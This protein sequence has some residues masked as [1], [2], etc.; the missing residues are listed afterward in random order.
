MANLL[1][2]LYKQAAQKAYSDGIDSGNE[3]QLAK[4]IWSNC[5]FPLECYYYLVLGIGCELA[6]IQA[7]KQGFLDE[8]ER[9][10]YTAKI[11]LYFPNY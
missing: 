9:A 8:V 1:K 7:Q 6:D 2:E 5:K 10:Y 3:M 4:W 11:S